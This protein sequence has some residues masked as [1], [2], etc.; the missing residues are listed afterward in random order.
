MIY[1]WLAVVLIGLC[2]S[3][4]FSLKLTK[5]YHSQMQDAAKSY[6]FIT[7]MIKRNSSGLLNVLILF[8][9]AGD[10]SILIYKIFKQ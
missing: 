5:K 2:V 4:Y 7:S 8:S 6:G 10:I 9:I 3:F 1:F